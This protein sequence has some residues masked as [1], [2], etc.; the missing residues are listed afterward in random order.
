M[1]N[2]WIDE[3]DGRCTVQSLTDE[4]VAE[5]EARGLGDDVALVEDRVYAAYLQHC[6]QDGIWQTFLQ[7]IRNKQYV[8][9]R[10]R[11]LRPREDADRENCALRA[12]LE[13]VRRSE[14]FFKIR[15]AEHVA[16]HAE[17][18]THLTCVYPQPGCDL[19]V[20]PSDE[21]REDAAEILESYSVADA[22]EGLRRQG[23]CCGSTH[24]KLDAATIAR[25]KNTGGFLI[26]DAS[27][28]EIA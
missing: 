23:C 16:V 8:Q 12:E 13:R 2:I 4:K 15:Y 17:R 24:R 1:A 9:R 6:G 18:F 11:Q 10:E 3:S 19:T 5:L 20:L 7:S 14:K 28:A 21:W 27:A 26:E 25:L 22:A